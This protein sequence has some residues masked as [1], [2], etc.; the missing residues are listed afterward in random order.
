M[1]AAQMYLKRARD[2]YRQTCLQTISLGIVPSR[3]APGPCSDVEFTSLMMNWWDPPWKVADMV[4]GGDLAKGSW[5]AQP[6][7]A[8]I[9]IY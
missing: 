9:L 3:L 6:A 5:D 7:H 1:D 4:P 8:Y 2:R